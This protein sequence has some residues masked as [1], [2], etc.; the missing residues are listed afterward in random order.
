MYEAAE[1][2][3][4]YDANAN[5][6]YYLLKNDQNT[7]LAVYDASSVQGASPKEQYEYSSYGITNILDQNGLVKT[8]DHD[9]NVNTPEV[10]KVKSDFSNPFGYH[11]MWRD[12]HTG[13]YHTHYRLYDPQHVRWLTPD[14]AGYRDGQNLYRFYAGPNGVDVLGLDWDDKYRYPVEWHHKYPKAIFDDPKRLG[15][16]GLKLADGVNV[17]AIENGIFMLLEDHTSKKGIHYVDKMEYLTHW[18]KWLKKLEKSGVSEI[19]QAM[20][21]EQFGII[22]RDNKNIAKLVDKSFK[23]DID[24]DAWQGKSSAEK[25][26]HMEKVWEYELKAGVKSGKAG[27]AAEKV[28]LVNH[29]IKN[30]LKTAAPKWNWQKNWESFKDIRF[31]CYN[32]WLFIRCKSRNDANRSRY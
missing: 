13:L 15:K 5:E 31:C 30:Y 27:L 19:T 7:V 8:T 6:N 1:P 32:L 9:L 12:E 3:Y 29:R 24:Y 21:D 16:L 23:A 14:P 22:I 26:A 17:H 4:I 10:K 2:V 25:A 18:N 28:I 20:L 11:G